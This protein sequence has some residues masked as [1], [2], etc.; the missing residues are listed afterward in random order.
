M[1]EQRPN[2]VSDPEVIDIIRSVEMRLGT[3]LRD[4]RPLP[5]GH[6]GLTL[7]AERCD[8]REQ[9][10]IKAT[11]PGRTA[12]GRHDVLRQARAMR[13]AATGVPVPR[14]LA[15]SDDPAWFVM[16]FEV[17]EAAE[18]AHDDAPSGDDTALVTARFRVA[19]ETLA[20]L[21]EVPVGP[22]SDGEA[23]V[24]PADELGK[25]ERTLGAIDDG[26]S[27]AGREAF[28]AL[29][30]HVPRACG[31]VL[32]HGDYRLGNILFD[33][34]NAVAVIDWE[35]WSVGDPRVDLGWYLT[36]C[37]PSNFPSIGYLQRRLPSPVD[38]VGAYEAHAGRAVEELR[39]FLALGA[40]KMGV[41]MAHN[42]ARHR[43]GR[44]VD[45]FQERLPP[46]IEHLLGRA[47][48]LAAAPAP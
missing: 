44:H 30:G 27:R 25:W 42:L 20:R 13:V 34:P 9:I 6:S 14:L 39:W 21:H 8:D 43:S 35:I 24:A 37:D 19:T 4:A 41:V 16:S 29:A 11:P 7:T 38:V 2:G 26:F 31:P 17:G 1:A 3:R 28:D 47:A 22:L 33:G 36:F 32:V 46:T 40:F 45:P 18:P 5:G 23:I 48:T 15:S 12:V 10:V